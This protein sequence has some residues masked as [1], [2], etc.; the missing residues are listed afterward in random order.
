MFARYFKG[1]RFAA[2]TDGLSNTIMCGETL[3]DQYIHV[4]AFGFSN[5]SLTSTNI[6]I[7]TMATAAQMPKEGMNDST[8]HS[9]NPHPVMGGMKSRHPGGAQAAL[10]DGSVRM[11][12]QSD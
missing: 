9:I 8:L 1:V 4:S 6:P 2:V 11:F 3:P 12:N 5:M 10:G 7:N